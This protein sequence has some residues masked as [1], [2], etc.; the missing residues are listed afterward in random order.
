[1]YFHCIFI[2]TI[3]TVAQNTLR[4]NFTVIPE[5]YSIYLVVFPYPSNNPIG[6]FILKLLFAQ[7]CT[8]IVGKLTLFHHL[9]LFF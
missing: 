8:V 5:C 4:V 1:M 6:L 9:A 7:N 3:L 2:H